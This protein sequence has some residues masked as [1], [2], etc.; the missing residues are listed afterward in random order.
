MNEDAWMVVAIIFIILFGILVITCVYI[1]FLRN[2]RLQELQR[3]QASQMA[4]QRS[5]EAQQNK[6][7]WNRN[8]SHM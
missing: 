7:Y 8:G 2:R 3:V 5:Y 6:N 4:Y 1:C